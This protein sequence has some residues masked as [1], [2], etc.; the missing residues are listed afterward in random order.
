MRLWDWVGNRIPGGEDTQK[1]GGGLPPGG[2][3]CPFSPVS[4]LP[5]TQVPRAAVRWQKGYHPG[6]S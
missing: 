1:G 2:Q 3:N 4:E 5:L 6:R